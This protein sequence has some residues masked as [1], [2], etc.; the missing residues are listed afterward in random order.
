MQWCGWRAFRVE[1]L[2]AMNSVDESGKNLPRP[3]SE[4]SFGLVFGGVFAVI[5]LWPLLHGGAVRWW[6]LIVCAALVIA[7]VAT[8]RILA[9]LN[10]VWFRFG[11]LLHQITTPVLLGAMF[12][13]SVTPIAMLMRAFGKDVLSLRRDPDRAS[14]WIERAPGPAA[15]S[16]RNQF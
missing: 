15:E 7:A 3:G 10:L 1:D 4:R 13:L 11:E 5:A 2:Q 6:A 14:Y 9:P 16:M 8:P 12:F